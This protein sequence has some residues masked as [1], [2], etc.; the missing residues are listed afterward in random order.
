MCRYINIQE[1]G[2]NLPLAEFG[3]RVTV[4]RPKSPSLRTTIPEAV[5]KMMELKAGD[6]II[7]KVKPSAKGV[8][9]SLSKA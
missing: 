4:A 1:I 3:S 2:S 9:V 7:W 6:D 5:A 8:E